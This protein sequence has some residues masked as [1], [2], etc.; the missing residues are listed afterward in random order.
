MY[1]VVLY[2]VMYALAVKWRGCLIAS[3]KQAFAHACACT[4]ILYMYVCTCMVRANYKECMCGM[5][6]CVFMG[7]CEMGGMGGGA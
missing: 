3:L 6:K 4:Y 7:I 5:L 1:Y 2:N